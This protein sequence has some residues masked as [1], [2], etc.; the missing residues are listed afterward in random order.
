MPHRWVAVDEPRAARR[1]PRMARILL[2]AAAALLLALLLH[3]R[4]LRAG[5]YELSA[6]EAAQLADEL[7]RPSVDRR[8]N[9]VIRRLNGIMVLYEHLEEEH[10]AI[11]EQFSVASTRAIAFGD[12]E[13]FRHVEH[14]MRRALARKVRK[15]RQNM[16]ATRTLLEG[17]QQGAPQLLIAAMGAVY[18]CVMVYLCFACMSDRALRKRRL[19][20]LG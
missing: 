18:L 15:V 4:A 2:R 9:E 11:E 16:D 19:G 17:Q 10:W 7:L 20:V 5:A 6:E 14:A 12:G 1:V 13:R 3:G 8:L